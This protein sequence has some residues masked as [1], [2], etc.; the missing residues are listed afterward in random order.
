[1]PSLISVT[2]LVPETKEEETLVRRVDVTVHE[3]I[4]SKDSEK[5][6]RRAGGSLLFHHGNTASASLLSA[7]MVEE[8]PIM[9]DIQ[10]LHMK[11]P[12][13]TQSAL[14]SAQNK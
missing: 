14:T 9:P 13:K 8:R 10:S 7:G 6:R 12:D 11:I 4:K 3:L 5:W 1:M 2:V